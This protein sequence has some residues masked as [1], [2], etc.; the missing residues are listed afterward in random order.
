MTPSVTP[1][2][3]RRGILMMAAA[4]V[5]W[6]TAG[7]LTRESSIANGWETTFWRS[8]YASLFMAVLL[9]TWHGRAAV[10]RIRAMGWPGLLSGLLLSVMITCFMLA[11]SRTSTANTLMLTCTSPFYAAVMG[12]MFLKEKVPLRTWIA[13]PC[14]F[15]GIFLMFFQSLDAG[16]GKGFSGNLIALL[17]PLAYG[18]N[19]VI[20]RR[21]G[22]AIDMAPTVLLGA[23]FSALLALPFALPLTAT[24]F[25]HLLML[26]L[27]VVQLGVGCVLMTRAV[28][29]LRATEVGLLSLLET[30]LGPLWTWIG[31]GETP[32]AMTLVGG[33]IVVSALVANELAGLWLENRLE[34]RDSGVAR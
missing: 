11:L 16:G 21:S 30:I 9:Y 8:F 25:D 15:A 3:H 13:M 23:V 20:I 31:V 19:I 26:A 12:R 2:E 14:A 22:H 18:F 29:Y 5:C 28:R 33:A 6:S 10:A 4:A 24:P 17:V 34:N 32:A 7:I 1:R 27:G